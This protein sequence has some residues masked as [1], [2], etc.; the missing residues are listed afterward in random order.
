MKKISNKALTILQIIALICIL[1]V[2]YKFNASKNVSTF[3]LI[4][5]VAIQTFCLLFALTFIY[6]LLAEYFTN[7]KYDFVKLGFKGYVLDFLKVV[8]NNSYNII[9]VFSLIT[10][11]IYCTINYVWIAIPLM[12]IFIAM[13]LDKS[14]KLARA[15]TN[16]LFTLIN[17]PNKNLCNFVEIKRDTVKFIV[18][19]S[20]ALILFFA[21]NFVLNLSKFST[22]V[23]SNSI[24]NLN[25]CYHKN[26]WLLRS[27][28][29]EDDY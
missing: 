14:L 1:A 5:A 8:T 15:V 23:A 9:V 11:A 19:V 25:N 7:Q 20:G 4:L 22:C 24:L 3:S 16:I 6:Q 10:L 29:S 17:L 27:S 26:E 28:T 13:L 2:I 21:A 12:L 18:V